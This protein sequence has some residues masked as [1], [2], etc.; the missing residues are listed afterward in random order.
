MRVSLK[1]QF[2]S[3]ETQGVRSIVLLTKYLCACVHANCSGKILDSSS[4]TA[5]L[6]LQTRCG[7]ARPALS[8]C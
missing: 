6:V 3:A 8:M 1:A 5:A 7:Q 4:E 2:P